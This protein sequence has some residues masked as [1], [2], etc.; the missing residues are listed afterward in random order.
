MF[1][2]TFNGRFE[3][4]NPEEFI[5][6]VNELLKKYSAEYYGRI[7]T[8]NLGEYVDFQKVEEPEEIHE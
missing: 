7:H 5:Q 6:D 1:A 2:L 4:K 3:L 8:E